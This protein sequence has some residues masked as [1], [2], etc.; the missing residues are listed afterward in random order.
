M[1]KKSDDLICMCMYVNYGT[2]EEAIRERNLTTVEEVGEVT[3]AGTNCGGC[4]V[5]IDAI[6]AEVNI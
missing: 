5:D 4:H 6:L 3:E 2:I 1:V